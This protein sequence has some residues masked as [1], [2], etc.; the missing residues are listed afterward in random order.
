[1]KPAIFAAALVLLAACATTPAEQH[2]PAMKAKAAT[3]GLH[4]PVADPFI[5]YGGVAEASAQ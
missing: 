1:M 2:I 5:T 3:Y 4:C